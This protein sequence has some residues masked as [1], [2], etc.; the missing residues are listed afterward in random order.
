MKVSVDG[1]D[2]KIDAQRWLDSVTTQVMTGAYVDP[3]LGRI[4]V[5]AW[6]DTWLDGLAHVKPTTRAR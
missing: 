5:G 4:T 2:R 1:F 3:K 6:I